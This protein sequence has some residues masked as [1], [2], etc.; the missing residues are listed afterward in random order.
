MICVFSLFFQ[1]R[2]CNGKIS[3]LGCKNLKWAVCRIVKKEV[4][5]KGGRGWAQLRWLEECNDWSI[6]A[7]NIAVEAN[8]NDGKNGHM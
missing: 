7:E 8:A 3:D 1:S 6:R 4:V 2:T 5:W